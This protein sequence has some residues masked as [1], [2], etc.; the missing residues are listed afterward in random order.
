[1]SLFGTNMAVSETS[2]QQIMIQCMIL[3]IVSMFISVHYNGY[4]E[5]GDEPFDSTYLRR[6]PQSF[7]LG[8]SV[9]L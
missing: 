6:K 4:L 7:N 5:Y 8:M 3:I 1:M 2:I 9:C